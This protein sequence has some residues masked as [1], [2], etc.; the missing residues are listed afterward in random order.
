MLVRR[1]VTVPLPRMDVTAA[2]G[3]AVGRAKLVLLVYWRLLSDGTGN[4]V[5]GRREGGAG[6]DVGRGKR[7]VGPRPPVGSPGRLVG[8]QLIVEMLVT[9]LGYDVAVTVSVVVLSTV[10]R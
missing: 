7:V 2:V 10:Y 9:T 8:K 4:V 5:V 3:R 6:A 1:T